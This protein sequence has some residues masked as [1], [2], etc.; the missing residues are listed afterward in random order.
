M[1]SKEK[2][3]PPP[4][5][6]IPLLEEVEGQKVGFE[7]YK[8]TKLRRWYRIYLGTTVL[9]IVLALSVVIGSMGS[10]RFSGALIESL[11]RG[12]AS[13]DFMNLSGGSS[14]EKEDLPSGIFDVLEDLFKPEDTDRKDS[15]TTDSSEETEG[16]ED[17]KNIL[18][19]EQLYQF[20]YSAV[21]EGEIPIVPMDLSLTSY[22]AS[23]IYNTTGLTP[24]TQALLQ[25]DLARNPSVEYLAAGEAPTVLIVHTHGTEGYSENGAISYLDDGGELARSHDAEQTVVAEGKVLADRLSKQGISAVHCT[26]MHDREQY[27]DSY[28]RAEA[29]IKQYLKQYPSIRLVIDVHRDSVVKS[30]GELVRP[31][32]LVNGEASA[33]VMCVVGS[34]WGGEA[35][36]NWEGNL[37]LALQLREELNAANEKLCRPVYLRSSTYNQELAPYSLLLEMGA[38]GN[39]LEEAQ[40]SAVAVADA[41]AKFVPRL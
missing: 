22:G 34:D 37:A 3:L 7:F 10:G 6:E 9:A 30:T 28:A 4:R 21:P 12:I 32:T 11:A 13:L 33:Q 5:Q 17:Q 18:T 39:S 19:M 23:Y 38:S 8:Q 16:G 35:N 20:D 27:K 26:V 15:P 40:R 41:L 25:R 24:D 2:K 36:P 14:S 29:T 1:F 31:V